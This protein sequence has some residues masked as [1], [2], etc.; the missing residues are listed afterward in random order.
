MSLDKPYDDGN[1]FARIIRGEVPAAKVY[2]DAD[3]LA[4][5]DAFPQ[6][7]GHTLVLPKAVRAVNLLDTPADL[8]QRLIVR[9]Q[10]IAAA[11]VDAL[12]PAGVRIMQ[13]NGEAAGQSVFH[14]HFHIIPTYRGE[15]ERPHGGEAAPMEELEAVAKVIRERL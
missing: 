14:L 7:R 11:V 4:I 1:V 3:V 2:E 10:V 15:A 6:T 13:F 8:L 9:T 12:A 5:M